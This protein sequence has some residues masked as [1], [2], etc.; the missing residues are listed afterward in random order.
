MRD[1]I[2]RKV[3]KAFNGKLADAVSDFTGVREVQGEYKP[4]LGGGSHIPPITYTG[5]GV[6]G[7]YET[8]EVDGK[9]IFLTDEK[10]VALQDE[11]T[12]TPQLGDLINGKRVERVRQDPT[13]AVWI[14]QLRAS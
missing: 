9:Y 5:R 7:S 4:S 1:K 10:L 6:F 11:V 8:N 12:G 14:I 3:A 13:R 2:N